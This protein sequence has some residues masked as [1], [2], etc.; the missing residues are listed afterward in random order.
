MQPQQT[1]T[2]YTSYGQS[3]NRPQSFERHAQQAFHRTDKRR[4]IRSAGSPYKLRHDQ[5]PRYERSSVVLHDRKDFQATVYLECQRFLEELIDG[6][7]D[8]PGDYIP[9]ERS[10]AD[11]LNINRLTVR[12]AID[13]LVSHGS[14]KE[15]ARTELEY[16]YQGCIDRPSQTWGMGVS[17]GQF[18]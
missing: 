9:F 15:T 7:D 13:R 6:A 16:W 8:G 2:T 12:K 1:H 10:L 17:P 4:G 3:Q 11:R 5:G 18:S 14:R